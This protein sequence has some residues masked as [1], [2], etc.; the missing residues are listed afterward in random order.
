MPANRKKTEPQFL[1][2]W[3]EIANYLDKG[4]RTVQRY[5]RELSL[6]VRRP[7]GKFRGS[8]LATKAELDAWVMASPI[9]GTFDLSAKSKAAALSLA[10]LEK[11][12]EE[13]KRLRQQLSTLRLELRSSLDS[14]RTSVQ[15]LHLGLRSGFAQLSPPSAP[16]LLASRSPLTYYGREQPLEQRLEQRLEL[17]L[18][19]RKTS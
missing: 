14:L 2:G 12:A 1:S 7:A 10:A 15:G 11:G 4:V 18:E 16:I 5:E 3:K 19:P 6:P 17:R 13:M 8:V 9:R